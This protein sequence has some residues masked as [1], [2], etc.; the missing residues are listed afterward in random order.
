MQP[1]EEILGNPR[2]Q[3][4]EMGRDGIPLFLTKGDVTGTPI[5]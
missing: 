2:Q 4:L 3:P 5:F 1:L